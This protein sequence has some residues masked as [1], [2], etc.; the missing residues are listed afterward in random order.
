MLNGNDGGQ[1]GEIKQDEEQVGVGREGREAIGCHLLEHI[2]ASIEDAHRG[3]HNFLGA[4]T[5]QE[6]HV[7]L[8]VETLQ[9]KDGLDGFS[10]AAKETLFHILCNERRGR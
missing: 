9:G 3:S 5:C 1:A 10:H 2:L 8:P 6:T 7:Q 4:H